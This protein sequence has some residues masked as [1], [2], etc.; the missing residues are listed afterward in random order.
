MK[1]IYTLLTAT[2]MLAGTA[3]WS[4]CSNS[5][6]LENEKPGTEKPDNQQAASFK[7][8]LK[9]IGK[10]NTRAAGDGLTKDI[11]EKINTLY[12]AFFIKAGTNEDDYKL[13][14]IFAYDASITFS[15]DSSDGWRNNTEITKAENTEDYV[16]AEPGTVGDYLAYF[17]ANPDADM[18][19]KFVEFQQSKDDEGGSTA[20][21]KLSDFKTL[22]TKKGTADGTVEEGEE[23]SKAAR[24]FIML[25]K[26]D[27]GLTPD[28]TTIQ[29]INL[30][31]LAARFDFINSAATEQ[32]SKVTITKI[33]IN[34]SAQQ[35]KLVEQADATAIAPESQEVVIT[36]WTDQTAYI[37]AYTYENLNIGN[38]DNRLSIKIEYELTKGSAVNAT[39][40]SKT[41]YLTV[42]E[43]D[44]AVKRNHIYRI[45]MNGVTGEFS[46]EVQDWNEGTTVTVPD[47]NLSVAYTADDLG[48]IGDYI[49][50]TDGQLEFS[51]GGLRKAYLS[52]KL[53]WA[54]D[55]GKTMPS[56]VEGKTC[57]GVVF[58]TRVSETDKNEHGW[59]GYAIAPKLDDLS[60]VQWCSSGTNNSEIPDVK[61]GKE[62][63]NDMD[64]YSHCQAMEKASSVSY[65]QYSKIKENAKKS[66]SQLPEGTSGWY[67]PSIGQMIDLYYNLAGMT[68][69]RTTLQDVTFTTS[70]GS[71]QKKCAK[72]NYAF[73]NTFF[74][75]I[76][77]TSLLGI[78]KYVTSSSEVDATHYAHMHSGSI[79]GG[80]EE[81]ILY[82][83]YIK[84]TQYNGIYT[85]Y[86]FAFT[87]PDPQP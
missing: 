19:A 39:K 58:S 69:L 41:I 74:Q 86:V 28:D 87:K 54:T 43:S 38:T 24:G 18:K 32:N 64:G 79:S 48:K 72:G 59:T 77:S 53:E 67:M 26:W 47:K 81:V 14:R 68:S 23:G 63:I 33:T 25:G 84:T 78:Q 56:P 80:T 70:A 36:S 45:Y 44:L 16:I 65:P 15:D 82:A 5:E 6:L 20:R 71:D 52:G 60:N 7:F 22:T 35:S 27:I 12:V 50:L 10:T 37:S 42:G 76:N 62:M 29:D 2:L 3:L 55:Q 83:S 30:E 73:A 4:G 9:G 57:I 40:M 51:D 61:T 85:Y 31:R 49:Y 13:H 8:N 66:L 75:K 46:V 1:Q 17:I 11:E 34:K 21:T